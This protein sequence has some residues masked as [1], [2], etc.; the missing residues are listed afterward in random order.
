MS[1]PVSMRNRQSSRG[2]RH[3][4]VPRDI[5]RPGLRLHVV[6]SYNI[7]FR[8]RGEVTAV[9]RVLHGARDIGPALFE[10]ESAGR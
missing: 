9:L 3:A 7:C 1:R 6:G 2:S 5:L 10:D 8:I 4:G